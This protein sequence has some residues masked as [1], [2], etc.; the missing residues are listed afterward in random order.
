MFGITTAHA[1]QIGLASAFFAF[2]TH[3]TR[4]VLPTFL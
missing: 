3:Y 4:N 2:E 1:A